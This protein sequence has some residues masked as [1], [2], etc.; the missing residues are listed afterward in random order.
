[1][2]FEG[3][4]IIVTGAGSGIGRET[5]LAFAT[6]GA[7][8]TAEMIAAEGGVA[9]AIRMDAGDEGDVARTVA[10]A[11]EA[12][13]GLDVVYANAGIRAGSRAF[14]TPRSSSGPRCCASI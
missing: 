12:F 10:L 13:G 1:M 3:K 14:S 4:S 2:R 5:A 9:R 6:E 7:E 8:E 11:C